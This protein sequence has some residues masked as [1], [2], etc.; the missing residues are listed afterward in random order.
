MGE[1]AT[2][3]Q[4]AEVRLAAGL[5]FAA[6]HLDNL[7]RLELQLVGPAA[8]LAGQPPEKRVSYPR[9]G[10]YAPL[11]APAAAVARRYR[12]PTR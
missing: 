2:Y 12:S 6:Q 3:F 10:V 8:E 5:L 11:G 1:H 4:G 7:R 9:R